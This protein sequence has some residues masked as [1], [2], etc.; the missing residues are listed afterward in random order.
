MN[1]LPTERARKPAT[2][3]ERGTFRLFRLSAIGSVGIVTGFIGYLILGAVSHWLGFY[4]PGFKVLSIED[5]VFTI[6]G[7]I[8]GAII[9]LTSGSLAVSTHLL[10]PR[11]EKA[12]FVILMSLIAFGF[13]AATIRVTSSPALTYLTKLL[14]L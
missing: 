4:E 5:P 1:S 10:E 14:E 13:G 11:D 12:S 8:T 2:L 9:C 6:F 7:A 3:L